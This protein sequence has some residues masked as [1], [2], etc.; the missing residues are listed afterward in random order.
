MKLEIEM[1]KELFIIQ[2]TNVIND[3]LKIVK[4]ITFKNVSIAVIKFSVSIKHYSLMQK[5]RDELSYI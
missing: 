3:F 5:Q 4:M 2:Y 1:S